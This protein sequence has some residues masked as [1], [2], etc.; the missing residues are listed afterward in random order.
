MEKSAVKFLWH[1]VRQFKWFFIFMLF[2]L[3]ISQ[4]SGQV[5]PY[6]VA[7]I[8]DTAASQT[9]S[10]TY[11]E[12]L[13]R[14]TLIGFAFGLIK[15]AGY[16]CS[17][18][19][20]AKFLPPVKTIIISD[21]FKHVN[22]LST[23]YFNDEMSGRIATK[24]SQ[25]EKS[26]I[27]SFM[28][29]WNAADAVLWIIV[30][31]CI[32]SFISI[33]FMTA[34]IIW[35][36]LIGYA[37]KYLGKKRLELGRETS[38]QESLA[39]GVVVDSIANYNEVKSFA[40]FR[41]EQLNLL[42]HLKTLRKADSREQI[43][44]A[45]IHLTQ[46]LLTVFSMLGFIFLTLAVF[47][48]GSI[49]TTEFIYATSLFMNLSFIVFGM[50][51]TYSNVSRILGSMQS[52]LDT[53]AVEPE[54]IDKPGAKTLKTAK[55]SISFEHVSFG[56]KGKR[57]IFD[58]LNIEIKA[59]EKIGLVGHSGAGKSTLIKLVDRYY[60][61]KSGAI[62]ING[63]DIRDFSQESLHQHIAII[64]QD[65]SLFNRSLKENIR[66]GK[67]NATEEEI[68]KAAQKASADIFIDLMPKKYDTVVGERGVV[69][70][71]GER[72]RIAI[73]RAILKN[74]PILIFD[75]A[76]SA[77]DSHSEQHIQKSLGRLMK[78]KTVIAIAHRLSTLREMDRILV[79]EKGKI[80]EEGSHTSLLRQKGAYYKL[81]K[82]QSDGFVA[83]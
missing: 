33:Y 21:I 57:K 53:L 67:T 52:A 79:F 18:F 25:L 56:Y 81:Y 32:L 61:V 71:G 69:L 77:L 64:P 34:L 37:V 75:E 49:N 27:E 23:A 31:F 10:P 74:A 3:I 80:I 12:D 51:W 8:F 43:M 63:T 39:N 6:F 60:D 76:T 28:T 35:M 20:M 9:A 59:G 70:S 78:N 58:D 19:I 22:K 17:F 62:K 47:K 48:K 72:Q 4:S 29:F 16:E 46:N 15:I 26:V 36:F 11:W 14:L 45:R 82:M 68:I 38:K 24:F 2:C 40:N 41:F 73:A 83:S 30:T 65:I 1:Y 42:K 44:K 55:A 54:I 66:Y 5:Y 50:T 7:K 13:V